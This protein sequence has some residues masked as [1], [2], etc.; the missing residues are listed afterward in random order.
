MGAALRLVHGLQ[1]ADP[2]SSRLV[3]VRPRYVRLVT[4]EHAFTASPG[5]LLNAFRRLLAPHGTA[6]LL[7]R[8]W[9]VSPAF[10]A[11][12]KSGERKLTEEHIAALPPVLFA[13][14]QRLVDSREPEQLTFD[15]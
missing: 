3:E 5:E 6:S 4:S 10:V 11:M 1:G 14:F 15:F 9:E 7:A 2:E 13:R 8:T 12:L